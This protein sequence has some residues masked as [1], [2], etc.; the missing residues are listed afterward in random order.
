MAERNKRIKNSVHAHG[1]ILNVGLG[2]GDSAVSLLDLSTVSDVHTI[3]ISQDIIDAYNTKHGSNAKHKIIKGDATDINIQ[4]KYD[5]IY[6]DIIEDS[7]D[8]YYNMLKTVLENLK[9]NKH[10]NTLLAIEFQA[11]TAAERTFRQ[12]LDTYHDL[13][14]TEFLLNPDHK[15][16]SC[17]SMNFYRRKP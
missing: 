14:D 4:D 12:W 8:Y 10:S 13:V 9:K 17:G 5:L 16:R 15:R 7:T 3:E 2:E 11:D 1:K 6:I